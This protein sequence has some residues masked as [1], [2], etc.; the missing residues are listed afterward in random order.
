MKFEDSSIKP[1]TTYGKFFA[2]ERLNDFLIIT[3]VVIFS[4]LILALATIFL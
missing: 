3:R 4:S 2:K 1:D